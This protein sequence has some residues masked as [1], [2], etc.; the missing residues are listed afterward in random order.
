MVRSAIKLIGCG[1]AWQLRGRVRDWQ[2]SNASV[3]PNAI[4]EQLHHC[5]QNIVRLE[6]GEAWQI[7]RPEE[8]V[9]WVPDPPPKGATWQGIFKTQML[10]IDN[11]RLLILSILCEAPYT[12]IFIIILYYIIFYILYYLLYII[13]YILLYIILYYIVLYYII[14]YC[15]I[16][17]YTKLYFII[18]YYI[19]L[20]YIT[21]YYIILNY[22]I[23][24]Y[25]IIYNLYDFINIRYN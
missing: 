25:I 10:R 6:V 22:I 1:S 23:L 8:I 7:V 20:Y 17:Y 12:Y 9:Y 18:L 16:L 15:I 2:F 13:Y 3:S 19:L 14:L 24:Y 11:I 4:R 21:L 5:A